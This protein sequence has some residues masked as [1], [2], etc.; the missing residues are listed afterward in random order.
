[1][2]SVVDKTTVFK[3]QIRG[4]IYKDNIK[5]VSCDANDEK[6]EELCSQPYMNDVQSNNFDVKAL[7]SYFDVYQEEEKYD[8]EIFK[9]KEPLKRM[10]SH[11]LKQ[12]NHVL[13]FPPFAE[14]GVPE[15]QEDPQKYSST[16]NLS[17]SGKEWCT[18]KD[19]VSKL[20]ES[21]LETENN[22]SSTYYLLCLHYIIVYL[23]DCRYKQNKFTLFFFVFFFYK[24]ENNLR[25][26][27]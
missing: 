19:I 27:V 10:S 24:Q 12:K 15:G 3:R 7:K 2:F 21:F 25:D 5:P 23:C 16:F 22:Y 1:M 4:Q 20:G 11:L 26:F 13:Q 17:E 18:F 8:C 9:R 14:R 6:I